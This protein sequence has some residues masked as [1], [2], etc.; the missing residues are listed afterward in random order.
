MMK[1][2]LDLGVDGFRI[3]SVA[4]FFE[5]LNFSILNFSG[6]I[7]FQFGGHTCKGGKKNQIAKKCN[8]HLLPILFNPTLFVNFAIQNNLSNTK[9]P[10]FTFFSRRKLPRRTG[11]ERRELLRQR[12]PAVHLQP[13]RSPRPPQEVQGR[14]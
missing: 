7:I 4:H 5:G 10:I 8:L 1:Y 6:D 9:I 14:P 3:D 2:W 12:V 13:A 11:F